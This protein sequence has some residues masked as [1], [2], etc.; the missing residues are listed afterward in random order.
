MA[1]NSYVPLHRLWKLM[2]QA[3]KIP[4]SCQ[5]DQGISKLIHLHFS[6]KHEL[7]HRLI[8]EFELAD[9]HTWNYIHLS[10]ASH[11]KEVWFVPLQQ[12]Q[13]MPK[14]LNIFNKITKFKRIASRRDISNE[15]EF[16]HDSL[17]KMFWS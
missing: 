11:E 4:W 13:V 14:D 1:E 15:N 8:C 2:Q 12:R 7:I 9:H 3:C 17:K 16:I 10:L 6:K 5:S